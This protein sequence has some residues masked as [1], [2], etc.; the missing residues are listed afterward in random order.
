MA[1]HVGNE[2]GVKKWL[3]KAK[4]IALWSRWLARPAKAA[5]I[6]LQKIREM[7]LSVWSYASTA[8]LVVYQLPIV[9][10]SRW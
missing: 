9:K 8:P 7:I 6:P 10:P 2:N 4:R 5:I 3:V 1:S